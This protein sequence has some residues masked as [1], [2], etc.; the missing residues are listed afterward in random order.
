MNRI[1]D[2]EV[3]R[4]L[5]AAHLG[6]MAAMSER[7]WPPIVERDGFVIE[8]DHPYQGFDNNGGPLANPSMWPAPRFWCRSVT[9]RR[10]SDGRRATGRGPQA[11]AYDQAIRLIESAG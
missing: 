2:I 8:S 10:L 6:E 5:V 3:G 1:E 9:L 7:E 4:A 11:E